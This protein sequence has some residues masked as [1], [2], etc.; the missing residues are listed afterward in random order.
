MTIMQ[1]SLT[2]TIS[3]TTIA[4]LQAG[5]LALTL[6]DSPAKAANQ[7]EIC[8]VELAES[9]IAPE[10]T[11]AACSEALIPEDLSECVQKIS[12]L[13][14]QGDN[15]LSACLQVRRPV[16]LGDCV[17]DISK[18]TQEPQI[19]AVLDSCRRSLLP[20]R[21]SKCVTGLSARVP[22]P[23]DQA[24]QTCLSAEDF[25]REIY[26]VAPPATS[27]EGIEQQIEQQ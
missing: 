3:L 15:A 12:F 16:E 7:F 20:S 14:V 1:N 4:S 25:P 11:A 27:E 5:F 17:T 6:F 22:L 24:L 26:T 13:Q 23:V 18:D 10:K 2:R 21:F 19:I 8:A 9:G